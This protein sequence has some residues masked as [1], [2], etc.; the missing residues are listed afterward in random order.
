MSPEKGPRRHFTHQMYSPSFTPHEYETNDA[1]K[2]ERSIKKLFKKIKVS[3]SAPK[4]A[5][6][7]RRR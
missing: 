1:G 4:S 7:L 6:K 5:Q 3:K 2:M